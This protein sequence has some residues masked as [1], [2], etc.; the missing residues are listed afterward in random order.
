MNFR[1]HSQINGV[2]VA[3]LV[4]RY[5]L[6]NYI[7]SFAPGHYA[8]VYSAVDL[9]TDTPCAFKV[10]RPEHLTEDGQARW[11][12]QA[13][14]NEADLLLAL[15]DLASVVDLYDLGYI[16]SVDAYPNDGQILSCGRDLEQFRANFYPSLRKG[17]RPYLAEQELPRA[18]N[19][20]YVMKPSSGREQGRLPVEEGLS[21]ALQ[22]GH[23]L[24]QA[25][26]R[27]IV[28]L[29]HK[30]EHVYWD[31]ANLCVIDWNS[32]KRVGGANQPAEQ[33]ITNDLHNLCVGI[34]YPVFTGAAPQKGGMRP[35]PGSQAAVESRYEGITELD[36][37]TAPNL[38]RA[39]QHFLNAGA[40]KR[41]QNA[42]SFLAEVQRIAGKFGWEFA[43][44]PTY[45]ALQDARDRTQI[46]LEKLRAS[47]EAA[48]D[49]RE[50]L[51][52]AATLDDINED[53]EN[54]LRRLLAAIGDYLNARVIP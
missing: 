18:H 15:D 8:R 12:A 37:S 45:A 36:F 52:E 2:A 28:F 11:E 21:L 40:A 54:E 42:T 20:F 7:D 51:L 53:V 4:E 29:D 14:I 30:L 35:Q 39:I 22:F 44:Q 27:D 23:L 38:S 10:M 43:G 50:Y 41:F 19:L 3:D 31:G 5:A 25:H 17:W 33:Q 24:Y 32:S 49:A 9:T 46:G 13:F 6:G 1:L 26:E 16:E 34:L 47:Q 48:R